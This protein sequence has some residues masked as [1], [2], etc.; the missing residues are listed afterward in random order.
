MSG[1]VPVNDTL[2]QWESHFI[3]M[4]KGKVPMSKRYFVS[5]NETPKAT[6]S[7]K[8]A[9]VENEGDE[10]PAKILVSSHDPSTGRIIDPVSA[11]ANQ[12]TAQ[13][14]SFKPDY[15]EM[16]KMP[17]PTSNSSQTGNGDTVKVIS[18][19]NDSNNDSSSSSSSS[20]TRKSISKK[21]TK[22]VVNSEDQSSE[23]ESEIK[24]KKQR[25]PRKS[26]VKFVGPD[27]FSE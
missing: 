12:T 7:S 8:K 13:V 2:N 22:K 27:A 1:I 23:P 20:K 11:A 21:S 3:D 14:K 17:T 4:A 18:N 9:R 19:N 5:I 24:K 25:K 10:Q 16:L 15:K 6:D 26:T